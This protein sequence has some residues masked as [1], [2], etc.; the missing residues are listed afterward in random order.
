MKRADDRLALLGLALTGV[1]SYCLWKAY[2]TRPEPA[3]VALL[4]FITGV[5]L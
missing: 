3:G 5:L 4:A 2:A 1:G